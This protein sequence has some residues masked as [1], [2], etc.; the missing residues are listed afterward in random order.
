[1]TQKDIG[2]GWNKE[3]AAQLADARSDPRSK[4]WMLGKIKEL[5]RIIE[6][7]HEAE[8]DRRIRE[9]EYSWYNN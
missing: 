7:M 5:E 4:Q 3:I 1:M 9:I 6:D 8:D 2:P